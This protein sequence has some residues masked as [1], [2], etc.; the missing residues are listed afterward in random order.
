MRV[1]IYQLHDVTCLKKI[2]LIFGKS[3]MTEDKIVQGG[4]RGDRP[5]TFRPIQPS[6]PHLDINV[7]REVMTFRVQFAFF[8]A[9]TTTPH[10]SQDIDCFVPLH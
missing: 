8:T 1:H 4:E 6:G 2:I 5:T 7:I 9:L 3:K 10:K